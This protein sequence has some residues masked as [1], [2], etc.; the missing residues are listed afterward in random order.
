[1]LQKKFNLSLYPFTLRKSGFGDN[2]SYSEFI[3]LL[4]TET[5]L[6]SKLE[7]EICCNK[8]LKNSFRHR[9]HSELRLSLKDNQLRSNKWTYCKQKKINGNANISHCRHLKRIILLTLLIHFDRA[10]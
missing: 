10:Y 8:D 1:M 5:S 7:I 2:N 3:K 4:F 9:I 6:R